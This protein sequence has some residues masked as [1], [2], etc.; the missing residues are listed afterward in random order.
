VNAVQLDLK[1]NERSLP[2]PKVLVRLC[3]T[4]A[5]YRA[6]CI[7]N[8]TEFTESFLAECRCQRIGCRLSEFYAMRNYDRARELADE[9]IIMRFDDWATMRPV[10]IDFETINARAKEMAKEQALDFAEW[11]ECRERERFS[12]CKEGQKNHELAPNV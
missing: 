4:D 7:E 1:F 5:K 3:D 10:Y 8:E 6:E 2:S 9:A 12:C 11:K